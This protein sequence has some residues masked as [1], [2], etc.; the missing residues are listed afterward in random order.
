MCRSDA[1]SP[2][3]AIYHAQGSNEPLHVLEKLHTKPVSTMKYNMKYEVVVSVDQAGILE[4][5]T[6]AKNDYKFPSKIIAFESKLD[7]GKT[8]CV[9]KNSLESPITSHVVFSCI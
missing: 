1:D 2:K 7:T 8:I 4:Y 3:I 5:W 9:T 6:T